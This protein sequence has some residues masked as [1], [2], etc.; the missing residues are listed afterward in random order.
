MER[1][2]GIEWV[3][4]KLMLDMP[5]RVESLEPDPM[6]QQDW[7]LLIERCYRDWDWWQLLMLRPEFADRCPLELDDFC[8][9]WWSELLIK[10]PQLADKCPWNELDGGDWS[11]LLQTQPQFA[12][13][14]PWEKLKEGDREALLAKQ[15]QLARNRR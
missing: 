2:Y 5:E 12:D 4:F 14:C 11:Q 10:H 1:L 9:W 3:R 8:G 13:K 7:E 15:L 6:T